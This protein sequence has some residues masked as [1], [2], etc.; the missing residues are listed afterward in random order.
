MQTHIIYAFDSAP[1]ANRFLNALKFWSV[2]DVEG[3]L[4]KGSTSIK[5]SYCFE[6]RGFDSTCS[7]LDDLAAGYGGHEISP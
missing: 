1:A 5:V 2:A 6:G 3:K 4:Y 7:E